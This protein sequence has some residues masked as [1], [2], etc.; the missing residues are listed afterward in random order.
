[1]QKWCWVKKEI[2]LAF[3]VI[4]YFLIAFNLIHFTTALARDQNQIPY[5]TFLE[6]N[7]GALLMG[8]ILIIAN[9]FSVMKI[10]YNKPLIY[11]I[12]W[13]FFI[14][15][16]FIFL[17]ISL[18]IFFHFLSKLK[19]INETLQFFSIEITSPVFWSLMMWVILVFLIFIIFTEFTR[20]I[21]KQE[22]KKILF[23]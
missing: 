12:A 13:K 10:F 19:N 4:I 20:A 2:S 6:I 18:D 21:G 9:T 17:V 5:F 7:L 3:P 8:K 15:V 16:F 11:N 14:Y 23:G 1:M 22:I